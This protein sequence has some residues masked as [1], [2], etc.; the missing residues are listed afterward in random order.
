MQQKKELLEL[1]ECGIWIQNS[2]KKKERGRLV[3]MNT[4]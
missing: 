2:E 4:F 1:K 3:T